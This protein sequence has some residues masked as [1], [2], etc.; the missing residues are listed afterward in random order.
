MP[1]NLAVRLMRLV[2]K[3]LYSICGHDWH[4]ILAF[5]KLLG[6]CFGR[7]AFAALAQNKK[8]AAPKQA[9]KEK[10]KAAR[11]ARFDLAARKSLPDLIADKEQRSMK[12]SREAMSDPAVSSGL[13]GLNP[14]GGA[15]S[16]EELRARLR[17]RI[18]AL[19]AQRGATRGDGGAKGAAMQKLKQQQRLKERQEQAGSVSAGAPT[20]AAAGSSSAG[21]SVPAAASSSSSSS[22][23]TASSSSSADSVGDTLAFGA[24]STVAKG[25]AG[26]K[27]R[28]MSAAKRAKRASLSKLLEDAEGRRAKLETLKGTTE[29]AEIKAAHDWDAAMRR[30]GGEKV[31]DD[32]KLLKR[33]IK[34]EERKK[35]KSGKVWQDRRRQEADEK[36]EK[37]AK[38]EENLMNRRKGGGGK[39]DSNKASKAKK[40]SASGGA[41]ASGPGTRK[42]RAASGKSGGRGGFEGSNR[43]K[44]N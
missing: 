9:I 35:K 14:S 16:V 26:I 7:F 13:P 20:A 6:G 29:G 5:L 44:L 1:L 23:A 28:D 24:V 38:R 43:Q 10:S 34:R 36:A 42:E 3:C 30:A 15:T 31:R 40:G 21:S 12:R 22:S 32:P 25:L 17:A 18:E 4:V 2:L 19:R 33:T 8:G 41:A 27:S 37:Q 11:K 39:G